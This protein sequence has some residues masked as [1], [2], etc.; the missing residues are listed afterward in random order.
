[1]YI[2][3][4]AHLFTCTRQLYRMHMALAGVAETVRGFGDQKGN[5]V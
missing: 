1:V 2:L 5:L 3:A 4:D